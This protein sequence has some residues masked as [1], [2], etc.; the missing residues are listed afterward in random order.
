MNINMRSKEFFPH[1][2][3]N[4]W[5]AASLLIACLFLSACVQVPQAVAMDAAR[6]S[7]IK[8]IAL[9]SIERPKQVTV[10]SAS[11]A[12]VIASSIPGLGVLGAALVAGT[13]AAAGRA[14]DGT[15][16]S[17]EQNDYNNLFGA[18][19]P[20]F[21]TA[22]LEQL[23]SQLES[24][25]FEVSVVIDQKPAFH[26]AK[27][28]FDFGKIQ[29]AAD[30]VLHVVYR[31][32]GYRSEPFSAK[33]SPRIVFDV[34]LI[35]ASSKNILFSNTFSLA[36]ENAAV[37]QFTNVQPG[38]IDT[39][40]SFAALKAG[41]QAS[42]DSLLSYQAFMA[43]RVGQLLAGEKVDE[44][45]KLQPIGTGAV[46]PAGSSA[47]VTTTT[48]QPGKAPVFLGQDEKLPTLASLLGTWTGK[49]AC[50][51]YLGNGQIKNQQGFVDRAFMTVTGGSATMSRKGGNFNE[52]VSGQIAD[53]FTAS[54]QGQGAFN[55]SP[56]KPWTTQFSGRFSVEKGVLK[57]SSNGR[58]LTVRGAVT[59]ECTAE[60]LKTPAT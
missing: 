52:A 6:R 2:S 20:E 22:L 43:K 54:L 31:E 18:N 45:E 49:Y 28:I 27:R 26:D 46:R 56:D 55:D 51:P 25:G 34:K 53:D 32:F 50:G 3:T 36:V 13:A 42:M 59:R 1:V 29:V 41:H 57:F 39:F 11:S 10:V 4:G 19:R 15:L 14:A 30:A 5:I 7:T 40:D 60:L 16:G 48:A 23:R 9:L 17:N 58:L 33:F 12:A 8:K 21:A 38:K 37:R 47:V 35:D 24:K 44:S